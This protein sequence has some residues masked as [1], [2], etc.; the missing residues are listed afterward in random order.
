MTHDKGDRGP[1]VRAAR[2][3]RGQP[4]GP[5]SYLPGSMIVGSKMIGS[6]VLFRYQRS[7]VGSTK[8]GQADERR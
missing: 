4:A 3:R 5:G 1:Q 6:I 2:V 8:R 7:A